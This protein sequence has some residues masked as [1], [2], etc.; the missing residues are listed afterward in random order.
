M[1]K[2]SWRFGSVQRSGIRTSGSA[3]ASLVDIAVAVAIMAVIAAI[4]V[5]LVGSALT[6]YQARSAATNV[7]GS[8]STTRYRAIA[9]GYPYQLVYT[10]ATSTY[11]IQS[12]PTMTGNFANIPAN[13]G[14]GPG[15]F[16]LSGSS[17][18]ARLSQDTILSFN[19]SGSVRSTIGGVTTACASTPPNPCTLTVTYR[20]TV[21][22]ISVTGLGNINVT[23]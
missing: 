2:T 18:A 8:I 17:V 5:P 15:P 14:N 10:A 23:P 22:T 19:P 12:D 3:G 13:D 20:N 11:V 4:A 21:E 16:L 7:A 6:S 1:D 9:A